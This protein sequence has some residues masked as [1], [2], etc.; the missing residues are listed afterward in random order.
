EVLQKLGH[1][2][3]LVRP[4]CR[5]AG[6]SA[7]WTLPWDRTVRHSELLRRSSP[8]RRRFSHLAGRSVAENLVRPVAPVMSHGRGTPLEPWS[9]E[10]RTQK[11]VSGALWGCPS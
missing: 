1:S 10:R 9:A 2:R 8:R 11:R 3:A 6:G 4:R 5:L 7:T